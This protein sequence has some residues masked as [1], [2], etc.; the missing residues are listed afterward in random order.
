MSDWSFQNWWLGYL[1]SSIGYTA[2]Y[3]ESDSFDSWVN[4]Y[5]ISNDKYIIAIRRFNTTYQ[6]S[7]TSN[8]VDLLKWARLIDDW[9]C[10]CCW[11]VLLL[12]L[13][14]LLMLLL[15]RA[16][17]S[18]N[19]GWNICW[20]IVRISAFRWVESINRGS[21]ILAGMILEAGRSFNVLDT[22]LYMFRYNKVVDSVLEMI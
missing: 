11:R 3:E 4:K 20:T 17:M 10:P 7:S 9:D 15:F 22:Y 12:L 21:S 2:K 16:M 6:N 13:M 5:K 18:C 14:L 8:F 1:P 19:N